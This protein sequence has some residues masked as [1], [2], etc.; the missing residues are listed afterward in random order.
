MHIFCCKQLYPLEIQV[1][2]LKDLRMKK[3]APGGAQGRK[4]LS[5][6]AVAAAVKRQAEKQQ[7]VVTYTSPAKAQEE[8]MQ[9]PKGLMTISPLVGSATTARGLTGDKKVGVDPAPLMVRPIRS[10]NCP[11]EPVGPVKVGRFGLILF[12]MTVSIIVLC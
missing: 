2:L 10:K 12:Y 9:L 6:A 7:Q 5:A 1:K 4:K 3:N 11:P 8:T